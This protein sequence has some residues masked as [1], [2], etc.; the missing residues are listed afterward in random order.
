MKFRIKITGFFLIALLVTSFG[1]LRCN[2]ENTPSLQTAIITSSS[3]AIE[4][5]LVDIF[6]HN[7][8]YSDLLPDIKYS[9]QNLKNRSNDAIFHHTIQKIRGNSLHAYRLNRITDKVVFFS[10]TQI[11][12]PFHY[13]W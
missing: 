8:N 5:I 10:N 9:Q 3:N 4:L 13:F 2:N 12:F 7:I 11:I 1:G 6:G